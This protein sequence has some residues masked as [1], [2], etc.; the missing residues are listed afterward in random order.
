MM[1]TGVGASVGTG[2]GIAVGIASNVKF[3]IEVFAALSVVTTSLIDSL[4]SWE[5]IAP[6]SSNVNSKTAGCAVNIIHNT[7]T[8][9]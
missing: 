9:R 2:V 8:Y 6:F 3:T 5:R 1:R 7:S 4:Q